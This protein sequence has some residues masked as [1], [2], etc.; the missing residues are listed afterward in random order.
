LETQALLTERFKE[1]GGELVQMQVAHAT[2][3]GNFFGW[4][5]GMPVVQWRVIKR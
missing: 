3:V 2:P 1:Q 4:R 5:A